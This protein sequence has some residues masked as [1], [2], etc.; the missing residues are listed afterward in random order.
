VSPPPAAAGP[1]TTATI[2]TPLYRAK[3]GSLG[4]AVVDWD[5]MYRGEKPM[6]LPGVVESR[7]LEVS[8]PG[9]EARAVPFMMAPDR[10]ALGKDAAKGRILL[11]G[12]DGFGLEI[13]QEMR[14]TSDSYVVERVIRV[15]NRHSVAQSAD[16]AVSWSAPSEWPKAHED[17]RGT[18]PISVVWMPRES[19]WARRVWIADA[20]NIVGDGQWIAFE[21]GL[22]PVGQNGVY[23][24]AL[25]PRSGGFKV[26]ESVATQTPP[27]D[28]GPR[29]VVRIGL[30]TTLPVLQPGQSWEGIVQDHIGPMELDRLTAL[31]VGL[32]R[33]IYFGGFPFPESWAERWGVPTLPMEWVVVPVLRVMQWLYG[34][35]GN[36][37]VAIIVLT[38]ITKVLFFPLSLKSMRSMKAMQALQPQIN[39]LRSKYKNDPQRLQR[40]TME[41]YRQHRVNPL[42][43]CL[44]MVVQVPIF[45]ALYVAL[46]VSP[47][48]QN[49][50]FVCFGKAPSW[51]PFVGGQDLWICD[52]A[53]HDPTYALPILMGVSMF[54]QQK[55]TPVMGDPRQAKIMLMMP[56]LFTF[57][58]LSLPS[59]LVLY[60]TLS[61]V[62]QIAQQYY[63]DRWSQAAR[64]PARA[65]KKA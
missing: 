61:N 55:M 21:S 19:Y 46:T 41:L 15:E 23:L 14:F 16:L 42:G 28:G 44:P 63:M 37:G 59:G 13:T 9:A 3:V 20:A 18:R 2:E 29:K 51:I 65:T 43:G 5:L 49:S 1:E 38:I 11:R 35:A 53:A 62:L 26:V 27:A 34:I 56:L 48:L 45:Y 57:M 39:A 36:Y 64:V 31:G 4:G 40:E 54:I 24:T 10:V 47:E 50:P 8:R 12:E 25:I 17:F 30:R 60:W 58:F 22:A 6:V 7:G 33:A 52:L 32:D